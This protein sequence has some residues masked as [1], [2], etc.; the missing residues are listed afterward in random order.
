M[1]DQEDYFTVTL[2]RESVPGSELVFKCCANRGYLE[3]DAIH[4][5]NKE[6]VEHVLKFDELEEKGL[7][8]S[9]SGLSY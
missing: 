6:Q 4:W 1:E 3:I 2:T 9:L 8:L 5:R 7:F